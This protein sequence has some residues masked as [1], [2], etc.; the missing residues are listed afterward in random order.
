MKSFLL[1]PLI[2]ILLLSY[3]CSKTVIMF[4]S[5]PSGA[6]VTYDK[7]FIGTTPLYYKVDTKFSEDNTYTFSAIK[8]GYKSE[9]KVFTDE[10]WAFDVKKSLPDKVH[11][12]LS[13]LPPEAL[14]PEPEPEAEPAD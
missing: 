3:G 5:E 1:L 7:R 9:T 10:D 2:S 14:E 4:T 12:V 11:F 6:V 8:K 13:P